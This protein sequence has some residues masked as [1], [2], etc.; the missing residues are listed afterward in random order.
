MSHTGLEQHE[1][2]VFS[3]PSINDTVLHESKSN[4]CS[5]ALE[6]FITTW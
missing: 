2:T 4:L 1:L 6:N 5:K 3:F